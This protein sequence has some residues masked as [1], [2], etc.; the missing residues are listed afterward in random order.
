[1]IRLDSKNLKDY[2]IKKFIANSE[3]LDWYTTPGIDGP[4]HA[5]VGVIPGTQVVNTRYI[6][7][8]F[9]MQGKDHWL[10]GK[11]PKVAEKWLQILSKYSK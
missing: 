2:P 6:A 8:S 7:Q 4:V 3:G 9:L 5:V 10:W 11:A 1:M